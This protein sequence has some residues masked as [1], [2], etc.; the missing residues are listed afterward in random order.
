VPRV[1]GRSPDAARASCTLPHCSSHL[2]ASLR[3]AGLQ[4]GPAFRLLTGVHS[5][6]TDAAGL[7]ERA[8]AG[9]KSDWCTA[10]S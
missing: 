7:E 8:A 1:M 5:A 10:G 6:P 4:Y 9:E 2:Y 3:A